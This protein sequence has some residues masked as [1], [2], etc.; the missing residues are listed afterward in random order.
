[1]TNIQ[2]EYKT[3][4]SALSASRKQEYENAVS[5]LSPAEIREENRI[6]RLL[7]KTSKRAR[8]AR[9]RLIKDPNAPKRPQ[10]PFIKFCMEQGVLGAS[11]P[12]QGLKEAGSRW[13]SMSDAEKRVD[14]QFTV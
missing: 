9:T 8:P 11:H 4:A 3:R 10:S 13:R 12:Q 5:N 1:M 7:K 14:I 6:R 2:K